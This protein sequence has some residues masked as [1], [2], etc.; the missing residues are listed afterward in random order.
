[1]G[2]KNMLLVAGVTAVL[3][4]AGCASPPERSLSRSVPA[5]A[6]LPNGNDPFDP[7]KA[8][9]L[10]AAEMR[11][12]GDNVIRYLERMR[13][14]APEEN[15]VRSS[16]VALPNVNKVSSTVMLAWSPA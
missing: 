10:Y 1:M 4:L 6:T 15:G 3:L 14:H 5:Y 7:S 11:G 13:G 16:I 12:R 8:S 2:P 9:P